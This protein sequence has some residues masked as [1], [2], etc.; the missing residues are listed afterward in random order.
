MDRLGF[1]AR[2]EFAE[3]F[4]AYFSSIDPE[5]RRGVQMFEFPWYP[6][7]PA[8]SGFISLLYRCGASTNLQPFCDRGFD[9]G[10]AEAQ[11]LAPID[12]AAANAAWPSSTGNWSTARSRCLW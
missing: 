3:D 11:R 5:V 6:D 1:E 4:D 12:P 9:R 8:A 7:F 10:I 2:L